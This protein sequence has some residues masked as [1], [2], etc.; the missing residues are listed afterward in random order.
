MVTFPEVTSAALNRTLNV[1]LNPIGLPTIAYRIW[2]L[3]E[4]T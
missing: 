1:S 2:K 4:V 3:Y